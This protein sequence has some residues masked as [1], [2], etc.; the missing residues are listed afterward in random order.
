MPKTNIE[1]VRKTFDALYRQVFNR[2]NMDDVECGNTM[3]L[4]IDNSFLFV[5]RLN[6]LHRQL[7]PKKIKK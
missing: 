2:S 7:H 6:R 1:A 4:S 3:H 5:D